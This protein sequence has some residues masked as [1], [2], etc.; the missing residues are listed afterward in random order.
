MVNTSFETVET[1][2]WRTCCKQR[3]HVSV[4]P[5]E[6]FRISK[7]MAS[8]SSNTSE[9]SQTLALEGSVTALKA[10]FIRLG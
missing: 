5:R 10:E 3:L 1:A 2:N 7:I 6:K 9:D 4:F 8:S